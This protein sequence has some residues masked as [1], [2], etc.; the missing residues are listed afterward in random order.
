[1][2]K[3]IELV[4]APGVGK[5]T[6]YEYL[7]KLKGEKDNWVLF[8][9][10]Y[11]N[12]TVSKLPFSALLKLAIKR[13][14][15]LVTLN[16]KFRIQYN[17]DVLEA[18]R[19]QNPE[20]VEL[21]WQ[22][23]MHKY[24]DVYGK[25]LRFHAISYMMHIFQKVQTV[26]ELTSDK[27]YVMDEGLVLN[28]NY[29]YQSHQVDK[30]H[31]SG[32]LDKIYLPSGIVFFDGD[33]DTVIERTLSRGKLIVR[34]ENLSLEQIRKSR[35]DILLEKKTFVKA[36]EGKNIPVLHLAASSSA[37]SKAEEIVTFIDSL[38]L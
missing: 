8:E 31:L 25:D 33:I 21:F 35:E 27:C 11:Q 3:Y 9:E 4:G 18:F 30:N 34:D 19:Q 28:M 12:G 16:P 6:T 29:F 22:T 32:L 17:H 20:L 2:A 38:S 14:I 24:H 7:K 10:E 13:F 23:L 36:I 26:K 5:S 15:G 1:M 37:A